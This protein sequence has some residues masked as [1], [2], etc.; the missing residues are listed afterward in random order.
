MTIFYM[1]VPFNFKVGTYSNGGMETKNM[2]VNLY[3]DTFLIN[4]SCN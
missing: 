1:A 2:G 3:I 4:Y